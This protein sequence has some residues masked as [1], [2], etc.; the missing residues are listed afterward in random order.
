MVCI[1]G[2]EGVAS[3]TNGGGGKKD[4]EGV[5]ELVL[6]NVISALR[7][8]MIRIFYYSKASTF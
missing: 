6:K 1:C 2:C 4:G 7:D 5:T 8:G 3:S